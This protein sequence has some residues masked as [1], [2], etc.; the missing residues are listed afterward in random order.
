M[1]PKYRFKNLDMESRQEAQE[2][3]TQAKV[4]GICLIHSAELDDYIAILDTNYAL[5]RPIPKMFTTYNLEELMILFR[6]NPPITREELQI[7][8]AAKKR[9]GGVIT[10]RIPADQVPTNETKPMF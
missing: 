3:Y 1:Q 4:Y 5:D 6:T 2:I 10:E 9:A 8:H 7:I